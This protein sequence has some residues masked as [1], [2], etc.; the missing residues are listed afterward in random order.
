MKKILIILFLFIS[1]TCFSQTSS[2]GVRRVMSPTTVFTTNLSAGDIVVDLSTKKTYQILQAVLGTNSL[3]TLVQFVDYKE[4]NLSENYDFTSK[5][6]SAAYADISA[7]AQTKVSTTFLDSILIPIRAYDATTWNNSKKAANEDA[8]RDKI[9]SMTLFSSSTSYNWT[10]DQTMNDGYKWL[11]GTSGAD[12][13][14]GSDGSNLIIKAKT[15]ILFKDASGTIQM[16]INDAANSG[17]VLYGGGSAKLQT[18]STGTSLTGPVTVND[19]ILVPLRAYNATTF[20]NSTR[21]VS[22]DSFRDKIESFVNRDYSQLFGSAAYADISAFVQPKV[23]SAFTANQIFNDTYTLGFGNLAGEF[24]MYSDGT[25][26]YLKLAGSANFYIQN[27]AGSNLF[28]VDG[29]HSYLYDNGLVKLQ[30]LSTGVTVNGVINGADSILVPPRAYNATTFN[31]STRAVSEDSFRDKIESISP[32]NSVIVYYEKDSIP[33]SSVETLNSTPWELLASP[34]PGKM[35]EIIDATLVLDY[36][37]ST[38]YPNAADFEIWYTGAEEGVMQQINN[39][40]TDFHDIA[41]PFRKITYSGTNKIMI[42][43]ASIYI[44]TTAS[45]G[46]GTSPM[47][48]YLTYRIITL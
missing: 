30:T 34:G 10:A 41:Q 4:F 35:Y 42:D 32:V 15:D 31:N 24:T 18:S 47:K 2:A 48:V 45:T 7:F 38:P 33:A 44:K 13:E 20:N 17:V 43:N 28:R 1:T 19:S 11:F 25:H 39:I 36:V 8:V 46:S 5:L 40:H 22:E 21:A 14:I 6:G 23:S 9:E 27:S 12:A 26:G 29:T 3:S 37:V 16:N